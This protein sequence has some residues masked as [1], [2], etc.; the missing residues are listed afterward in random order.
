MVEPMHSPRTRL[1]WLLVFLWSPWLLRLAHG[2]DGVHDLRGFCSDGWWA[3][4]V[5]VLLMPWIGSSRMSR[6]IRAVL[7]IGAALLWTALQIANGEHLKALG[8]PAGVRHL[9]YLLDPIFLK[10]SVLPILWAPSTLVLLM[11]S[12]LGAWVVFRFFEP[13]P[14][15][16]S[17][18]GFSRTHLGLLGAGLLV[19]VLWPLSPQTSSW[20]QAHALELALRSGF[21][22]QAPQVDVQ[23]SALDTA[24]DLSGALRVERGRER[25]VILILLEG[26]SGG[27]FPSLLAAQDLAQLPSFMNKTDQVLQQ[28]LLYTN[29]VNL[30]RQTNR[31]TYALLC[32]R[33]PRLAGGQPKMT[34]WVRSSGAPD[35][36][37]QR[38]RRAG[39]HTAYLQAA[40][41]PFMLKDQFMPLAGFEQVL[42]DS[43][44][45]PAHYRG[46][47]G[48]DDRSLLEGG[49]RL[50]RRLREQDQP[51][52]LTLLTVGTHH[53]Y[54]VPDDYESRYP[55]GSFPWAVS[56]LDDALQ[57]FFQSLEQ[58]GAR[59]DTLIL[60]ASDEAVGLAQARDDL[61]QMLSQAWGFLAVLDP[62]GI[63]GRVHEPFMQTDLPLS[64][65]DYLHIDVDGPLPFSGRSVF[66]T[67]DRARTLAFGNVYLD[68]VAGLD[69]KGRLLGCRSDG[70]GCS[71]WRLE[72]GMLFSPRRVQEPVAP[73]DWALLAAHVDASRALAESAA[74]VGP[75]EYPLVRERDIPLLRTDKQWIF[76][77]Q[78]FTVPAHAVLDVELEL[79]LV[80]SVSLEHVVHV[81]HDLGVDGRP[82]LYEKELVLKPGATVRFRYAYRVG[83]EAIE[84]LESRLWVGAPESELLLRV[85]TAVLKVLPG[86]EGGDPGLVLDEYQVESMD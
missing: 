72:N 12:G 45:E 30:Q 23:G 25:D 52:F 39:Y 46:E 67:Y 84:R 83:N 44:L 75:I 62:S 64:V 21:A 61:T 41:L 86:S 4:L 74:E 3:G 22:G 43:W 70:Q 10:G 31:G 79:T 2:L 69:A 27:Y 59:D 47:W 19:L 54:A 33:P 65:L 49:I 56:Y 81:H 71:K 38:L 63:G 77:G 66:R 6:A 37:P 80:G 11:L 28:G 53:P 13:D 78:S 58:L 18:T 36:L 32:G 82:P 8:A 20:R 16:T 51:Y 68:R 9:E 73:E 85:G 24:P 60:L 48:V 26:I 1:L 7:A 42:D 15:S 57:P 55:R 50:I 29:F 76:G 14:S 35:C 5:V 17:S 40:P 34:E